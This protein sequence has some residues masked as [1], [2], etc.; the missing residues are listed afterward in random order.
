M[1]LAWIFWL[2]LALGDPAATLARWREALEHR[3]EDI[4]V[5]IEFA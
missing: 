5:V 1:S 2:V 3:H 4:K